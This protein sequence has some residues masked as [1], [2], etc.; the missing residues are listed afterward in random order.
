M[1]KMIEYVCTGN[2]GRSPISRA[3]AKAHLI[4]LGATSYDTISSGTLVDD[5]LAGKMATPLKKTALIS[6]VEQGAE[7]RIYTPNKAKEAIHLV[8]QIKEM[9]NEEFE[10][11][12]TNDD[13]FKTKFNEYSELSRQYFASQENSH[14][15]TAA[16]E[17]G[18]EKHLDGNFKQTKLRYDVIAVLP[19]AKGNLEQAKKIY[20]GNEPEIMEV[21]S[22]YAL[23]QDAQEVPNTFGKTSDA[24]FEMIKTL[25]PI[26]TTTIDKILAEYK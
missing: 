17:L 14:C 18:I 4:K 23:D 5:I 1:T 25:K 12:Y 20:A 10:T 11:R 2:N 19:M 3:I 22:K 8:S 24:Y 9:N 13:E 7:G 16:N 26:V 15:I 6:G 21:V